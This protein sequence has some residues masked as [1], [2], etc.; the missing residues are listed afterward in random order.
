M[1][2]LRWLKPRRDRL[3]GRHQLL[4]FIKIFSFLF[5]LGSQWNVAEQGPKQSYVMLAELRLV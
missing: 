2:L 1:A 3:T 4:E 5:G